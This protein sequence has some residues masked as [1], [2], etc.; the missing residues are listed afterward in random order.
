MGS[1]AMMKYAPQRSC[2]MLKM[3]SSGYR[4]STQGVYVWEV[5]EADDYREH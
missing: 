4:A 2:Q 1:E 3:G 5:V